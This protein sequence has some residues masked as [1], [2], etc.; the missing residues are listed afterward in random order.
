MKLI[1]INE[2]LD[3]YEFI[4]CIKIDIEGHEYA[5]IE[6][7][8]QN[9]HKIGRLVCEFHGTDEDIAIIKIMNLEKN[10]YTI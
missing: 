2:I 8:I 3:K 1:D 7:L 4:D 9:K 6:S 10:I 5:I